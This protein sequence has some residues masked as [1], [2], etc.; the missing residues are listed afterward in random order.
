MTEYNDYT[1]PMITTE[2]WKVFAEEE[3]DGHGY[4]NYLLATENMTDRLEEI[5]KYAS[6]LTEFKN[7]IEALIEDRKKF[8]K[9]ANANFP[10]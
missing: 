5:M 6:D 10:K 7:R 8:M 9:Y 3:E 2:T 4:E 1:N